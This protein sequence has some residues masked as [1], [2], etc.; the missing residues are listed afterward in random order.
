MVPAVDDAHFSRREFGQDDRDE[1]LHLHFP[2]QPGVHVHGQPAQVGLA[3][4]QLA[5]DG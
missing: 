1:V 2:C 4:R 3:E 5:E